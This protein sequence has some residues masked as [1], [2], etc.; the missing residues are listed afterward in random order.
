MQLDAVQK[1]T[2]EQLLKVDL[3]KIANQLGFT[4]K[5]PLSID[6]KL[7]YKAVGLID[8]LSRLDDEEARKVVT[9]LS[10][11]LWDNRQE[12]WGGL[13]DFLILVL[14]RIG[15][16]PT[17]IMIDEG[18]DKIERKHSSLN[19][20]FNEISVAINQFTNEVKI[21]DKRYLLTD[22]QKNIWYTIDSQRVTG[23]SAPTSAG[24]SFVILLKSMQILLEKGGT[25]VY[26]VPNLS[27]VSQVS[28]DYRMQLDNFGLNEYQVINTYNANYTDTRKIFVL[29]QERAIAAF[30]QKPNPF[31]DLRLLVIDEI[32]NVE[33]MPSE[34]ELRSKI[35]YD[36]LIEFRYSTNAEKIIIAGPRIENIDE[37]ASNIF[38]Q[39][40]EKG[41]TYH[42]PVVNLTYSV[43]KR[44]KTYYFKQYSDLMNDPL[45]EKITNYSNISG[46]GQSQ[47]TEDYH[48]YLQSILTGLGTDSINIIFSPTHIQARKTAIAISK[49]YKSTNNS[50]LHSLIKYIKDSVH[51]NYSLCDCLEKQV[52]YHHGKL[53]HHVR[54]VIERAVSEKL[55]KNIVC[56]TT[57]MQ[58]VNLPAQ[59]VII[60]NPNLFI[61]KRKGIS[62]KKLTNYELA[63][64][65]GRAGRLL[66][67]FIGRT[68]ILDEG[69]FE[70][71]EQ[72]ITLFEDTTKELKAT[73]KD[74]FQEYKDEV[75]ASLINEDSTETEKPYS[76]LLPYIRQTV[77]RFG[78]KSKERLSAVGINISDDELDKVV[79]S[80]KKLKVPQNI[81]ILN[82]YWDP[83]AL[84]K[85]YRIRQKPNIPSSAS[86][87]NIANR[88][89]EALLFMKEH[90]PYYYKKYLNIEE[91]DGVDMLLSVCINAEKWLKETSLKTILSTPYHDDQDKIENTIS[92]LQNTISYRIPSLLKPLY[93]M[94]YPGNMFLN[95]IEMGA[96]KPVTRK[97]I[98]LGVPRET[99]IRIT[100]LINDSTIPDTNDEKWIRSAIEKISGRLNYWERIQL[101]SVIKITH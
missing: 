21:K 88:L 24:K 47:Y 101:D 33:H 34:D 26:I 46:L 40:S 68:I 72:Q 32:Q 97:I 50:K 55:I 22:F 7:L 13:K 29:T 93:D 85:L 12:N 35:L 63:N 84:D 25:I 10:A 16:S 23:I 8:E 52:S 9:T 90:F 87:K 81:C 83:I 89:K 3:Q 65:R 1:N 91:V 58:G 64:L 98:E 42:S 74:R 28:S 39:F 45:K 54:K 57:L 67:D 66:K 11:I 18:Y 56:T 79:N 94:I 4:N 100:S 82:R 36:T 2:I 5:E 51:D 44:G 37:L 95:F 48:Q 86:D 92:L 73:Y 6:Q 80:M 43:E 31:P 30:S 49:Q 15:L 19:S 38:D 41:E 71:E 99:A 70:M 76:F 27:L 78:D 61:R 53:P 14:N 20:I 96:Y 17:A 62:P 75:V 59:N 69:S 60:R 77:L